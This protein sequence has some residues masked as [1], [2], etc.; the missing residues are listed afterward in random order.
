VAV[1]T[2]EP[3]LPRSVRRGPRITLTC[4]C[5]E[6]RYLQYGERWT[7]EACGRTWNTRDIPLDQYA[8]VRRTQLR[9]RRVPMAVAVIS[10][11]CVAVFIILG[12]AFGGL[13]LVAFAATAWSMFVRPIHRRRYRRQ[14][15]ELPAWDIAPE[16]EPPPSR[17][18]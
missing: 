9:A 3:A 12:R 5:G 2:D 10:L 8:A 13:I 4:R 1:V 18:S 14:L 15:A 6:R 17:R 16:S 11:V 7:C